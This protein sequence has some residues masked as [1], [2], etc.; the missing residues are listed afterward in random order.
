MLG[1]TAPMIDCPTMPAGSSFHFCARRCRPARSFCPGSL[2]C[3]KIGP[4]LRW[5]CAYVLAWGEDALWE[6]GLSKQFHTKEWLIPVVVSR[7][8]VNLP[9]L[10]S[11]HPLRSVD[12]SSRRR[13]QGEGAVRADCDAASGAPTDAAVGRCRRARSDVSS[14]CLPLAVVWS[15][16]KHSLRA[17]IWG[18]RR[19]EV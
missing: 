1:A 4:S 6:E 5:R 7:R 16:R 10:A 8:L 11:R 15:A 18:R 13:G 2:H 12:Q 14:S 9:A 17:L 19:G 3:R